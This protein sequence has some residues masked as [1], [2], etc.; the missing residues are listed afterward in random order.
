MEENMTIDRLMEKREESQRGVCDVHRLL[1][2]DE[3][4][5]LVRWCGGC[6]AW[7]CD[8]CAAWAD[9]LAIEIE[10]TSATDGEY[11]LV[12]KLAAIVS[13]IGMTR[14]L[15]GELRATLHGERKSRHRSISA[16]RVSMEAVQ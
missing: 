16:H 13:P 15:P 11:V 9:Y 10:D 1:D 6:K 3:S 4:L 5:R 2:G 7:L 12:Q 8:D 14:P